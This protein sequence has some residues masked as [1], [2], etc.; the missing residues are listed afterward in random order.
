[1]SEPADLLKL[2]ES[3]EPFYNASKIQIA[4]REWTFIVA[5]DEDELPFR[6]QFIFLSGYM[7]FFACCAFA[8]GMVSNQPAILDFANDQT[9]NKLPN[10]GFTT[11][12]PVA[13]ITKILFVQ[14]LYAFLSWKIRLY[15]QRNR[16]DSKIAYMNNNH[17]YSSIS[18]AD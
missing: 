14:L 11:M 12:L 8:I 17:L 9:N 13:L 1:M 7:I 5:V 16:A 3:F 6:P 2:E 4:T 10:I 18:R 15:F